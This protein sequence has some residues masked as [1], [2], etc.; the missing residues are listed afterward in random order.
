MVKPIEWVSA[1]IR[2]TRELTP[3]VL[4]FEIEADR[5]FVTGTPGSHIDVVVLIDGR[6]QLRSYSLV[7]PCPDGLYR[8]AVKRLASSRGGS[9]G[10][11]RLKAGERLTISAPSNSFEL[12]YGQPEYLLLAG[13]IGIT[14]IYT[15]ALALK[16]AG[17]KFRLLYAAR[18]RRDLAL[19]DELA[20]HIGERL[21][22]FVDEEEQRIDIAGEIAQLDPRGELYVCGPFGMLEAVRR[23][24]YEAGRPVAHLRYETFGNAGN[25]ADA[26]FKIKIPRLGL[27][28]DVPAN[29][30][31]L[32]ALEDAGVDMIFGCR[33]GECGL[34]VLPILEASA[35]VDHRDVFF[36]G[37]ERATNGKLCTCVSRAKSGCI[38]VDTPDRIPTP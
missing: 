26:P 29:R 27:E 38:T 9:I 36:S 17:A 18:S 13:G 32:D 5:A 6:P 8:I 4:L 11:W 35:P 1:R 21:Q 15:M 37:E 19:A 20:R 34:C 30:S 14:P 23:L 3:D 22:L 28:V 33:R 10:M 24:W 16:Q 7:G 25:F 12:S 31:I 2:A